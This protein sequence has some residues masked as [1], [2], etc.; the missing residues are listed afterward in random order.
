[1]SLLRFGC[2]FALCSGVCGYE[3]SDKMATCF[4]DRYLLA[5]GTVCKG[6]NA[7]RD[8]DGD[9]EL[10]SSIQAPILN[11]FGD[12]RGFDVFYTGEVGDGAAD[13]QNS[14]IGARAEAKLVDRG[15]QESFSFSIHRA[16]T[17]DVSGAHLRV[18]MN[19]RFL[20]SL[21]LNGSSGVYPI[22]NDV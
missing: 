18:G 21:L 22:A 1:M 5:V 10:D 12:V 14:A 11:C 16:V 3:R 13:F 9:C 6:D 15:L 7:A 17:L 19:F 20:K 4:W 8:V 2:G